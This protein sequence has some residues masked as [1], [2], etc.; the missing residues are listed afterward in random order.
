[1][2][3]GQLHE[4]IPD[5]P[6]LTPAPYFLWKRGHCVAN[7]PSVQRQGSR[8]E[9]PTPGTIISLTNQPTGIKVQHAGGLHKTRPSHHTHMAL[10]K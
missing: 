3:G 5:P 6:T 8:L 10:G 7:F 2:K 4:D 9:Y 1:M